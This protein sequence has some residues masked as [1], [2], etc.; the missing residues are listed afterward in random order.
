[1]LGGLISSTFLSLLYIPAIFTIVDDI[2]GWGR[3][4]LGRMFAGQ[5]KLADGSRPD[6]PKPPVGAQPYL[7]D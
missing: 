5:R 3:R 6:A 4:M 7:G 2:A 1:M